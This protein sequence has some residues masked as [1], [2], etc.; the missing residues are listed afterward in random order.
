MLRSELYNRVLDRKVLTSWGNPSTKKQDMEILETMTFTKA[1]DGST[2]VLG[3]Y[4]YFEGS[5]M[6]RDRKK[7]LIKRGYLYDKATKRYEKH[8][9]GGNITTITFTKK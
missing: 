6:L 4:L 7:Y 1:V 8:F 3:T 5:Q 2:K 9:K